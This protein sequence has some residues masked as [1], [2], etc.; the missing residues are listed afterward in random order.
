[1]LRL[2][3]KRKV[4]FETIHKSEANSTL[5]SQVDFDRDGYI[6]FVEFAHCVHLFKWTIF[7][8]IQTIEQPDW[9]SWERETMRERLCVKKHFL[10]VRMS[11]RKFLANKYYMELYDSTLTMMYHTLTLFCV[12][13]FR[14][15]VIVTSRNCYFQE[16]L[17]PGIVTF[18]KWESH[19]PEIM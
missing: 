17:L 2:G 16:L 3:S 19:K 11:G 4:F 9:E 18:R 10:F 12:T 7:C 13:K 1:M 14:R 5:R 6:S 15:F 8:F